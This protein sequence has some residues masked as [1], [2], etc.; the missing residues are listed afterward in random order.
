MRR[1]RTGLLALLLPALLLGCSGVASP[2][3][4]PSAPLPEPAKSVDARL[5]GAGN[6]LGFQL[7]SSLQKET[8]GENLFISPTSVS[9][10]LSLTMNGARGETQQAMAKA[11]SL[12]GLSI[13]EVNRENG[14]LQ[15]VVANPDPKVQLSIANSLWYKQGFKVNPAFQETGKSHYGAEARP[16]EFGAPSAAKT[17]NEWVDKATRSKIPSIIQ[18]TDPLDRMYIVNAI[19]FNGTWQKQFDPKATREEPF[20]LAGGS[21]QQV[22]MMTQSGRFRYLKGENFAAA[23][24][25]YGEGRLNLYL[26][27]PDE[28]VALEKFVSDL[29]PERWEDWMKRFSS[30]QG[31]VS[32]PKL[33]L[34]YGAEL[35]ATMKG[36][37]MGIAFT[38]Q[39]DFSGLFEGSKE[40][41]AISFI[42]HK[43]FLDMN[44]KGTEAAAVTAVG[45][46]VT[47][48][49]VDPPFNLRADRPYFMAI[50]DDQT[51][52]ILFAGA[53]HNPKAEGK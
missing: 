17:I 53:I 38:D 34:S 41:L 35:T 33:K 24:L 50:R 52:A 49:P 1:K 7:L 30:S 12:D 37:G 46:S 39:A 11:L 20:Q 45:V 42:L 32:L 19:Y 9:L 13:E 28:G 18:K 5:V 4:T 21:K 47:S 3:V 43:T 25:P 6:R 31:T 29:T 26:F 23:A 48:A 27:V 22:P 10:A 14:A 36:L 2:K 8:P 16:V 51:G 44:E 15:T 40:G